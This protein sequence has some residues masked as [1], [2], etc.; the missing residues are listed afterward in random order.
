MWLMRR[1]GSSDGHRSQK[2]ADPKPQDQRPSRS[3]TPTRDARLLHDLAPAH[4]LGLDE[5]LQL[6]D[7]GV[8]T[9]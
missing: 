9:G 2:P 7:E 6:L 1:L 4:D 5:A 8:S 3:V